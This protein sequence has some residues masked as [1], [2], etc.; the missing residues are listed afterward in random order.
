M[1]INLEVCVL[2]AGAANANIS[3]LLWR[4]L[5]KSELLI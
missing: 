2:L 4:G 1:Y 3:K 5:K